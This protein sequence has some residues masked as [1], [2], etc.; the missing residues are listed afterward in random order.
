MTLGSGMAISGGGTPGTGG[1][2][3]FRPIPA[4][5]N[6]YF[7]QY[8]YTR[9]NLINFLVLDTNIAFPNKLDWPLACAQ[10]ALCLNGPAWFLF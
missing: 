3:P 9:C 10:Y 8:L 2:T 7:L 4:E 6:N 1:R 5:F